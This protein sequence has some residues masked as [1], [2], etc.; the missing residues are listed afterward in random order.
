VPDYLKRLGEEVAREEWRPNYVPKYKLWTKALIEMEE[1]N[2]RI[3]TPRAAKHNDDVCVV[4][5]S[6]DDLAFVAMSI[7]E[8]A[9]S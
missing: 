3:I 6:V 4:D 5:V 9:A 1:M 7:F 2:L 8:R